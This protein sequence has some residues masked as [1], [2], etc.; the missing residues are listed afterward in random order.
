[1]W[2]ASLRNGKIQISK[3]IDGPDKEKDGDIDAVAGNLAIE[4]TSIDTFP[5]QR[6]RNA[7]LSRLL[8]DLEK[9]VS[10]GRHLRVIVDYN[11]VQRN[12]DWPRARSA[13][14][15]W[16]ETEGQKI[17]SR[18][19]V[20]IP[21]VPFPF[22]VM[23]EP[24]SQRPY[25]IW[26]GRYIPEKDSLASRVHSQCVR[27]IAKLA[28]Y[29]EIG[30]TTILL[31]ESDDIASMNELLMADALRTAFTGGRPAG[32]DEIWY[33]NT[34]GQPQLLFHDFSRIWELS[35]D[36]PIGDPIWWPPS[37]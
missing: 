22:E 27:K 3:L 37:S 16:L 21:G 14:K 25:R 2:S 31:L 20:E 7:W 29:R 11:A 8:G 36:E 23:A 1:M 33:V 9:E 15:S 19:R 5:D 30:S 10:T 28:P 24:Y 18:I 26:F 13:L 12:Q 17:G 6:Q 35:A 34:A 4:H 32:V